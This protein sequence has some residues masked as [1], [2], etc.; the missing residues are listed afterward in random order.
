MI[1]NKFQAMVEC[2]KECVA[3]ISL[4][5]GEKEHQKKKAEQK[6]ILQVD[7]SLGQAVSRPN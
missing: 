2:S 3:S 6:S 4:D 7:Q 5:S 1:S